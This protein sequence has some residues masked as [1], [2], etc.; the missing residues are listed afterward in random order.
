M[1]LRDRCGLDERAPRRTW[2]GCVVVDG[3]RHLRKGSETGGRRVHDLGAAFDERYQCGVSETGQ[4]LR[5][6]MHARIPIMH[7][8]HVGDNVAISVQG[9]G[10]GDR[11]CIGTTATKRHNLAITALPLEAGYDRGY[12]GL[13]Q[14]AQPRSCHVADGAAPERTLGTDTGLTATQR[15]RSHTA[16]PER[17]AQE[18][19]RTIFTRGQ[20][21]INFPAPRSGA[22]IARWRHRRHVRQQYV[23]ARSSGADNDYDLPSARDVVADP[24]SGPTYAPHAT[25]G[26]TA[27]LQYERP[28]AWL[29]A[30]P[31]ACQ[32]CS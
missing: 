18:R 19:S 31:R 28:G 14:A 22:A 1:K 15:P 21:P 9:S 30:G 25:H 12:A 16:A 27:K 26:R 11:S 23:R 32:V 2:R 6:G 13:E 3:K 7:R 5:I 20:Q 17:G 29:T 24:A 10:D 4:R 8:S